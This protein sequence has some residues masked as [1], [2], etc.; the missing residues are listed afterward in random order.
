MSLGAGGLH[1]ALKGPTGGERPPEL[2]PGPAA[3]VLKPSTA[4]P[5]PLPPLLLLLG[6]EHRA[7]GAD[8][9]GL[10]FCSRA[11]QTRA[12][13]SKGAPAERYLTSESVI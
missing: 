10:R 7:W 8:N 1:S 13:P 11:P 3:S 6:E 5:A 2:Q 4:S 9:T 12:F